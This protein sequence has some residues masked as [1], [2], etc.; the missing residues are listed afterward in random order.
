[1]D[2]SKVELMTL[3]HDW[4]VKIVSVQNAKSGQYLRPGLYLILSLY[5]QIYI[6]MGVE[7]P[8]LTL[9]RLIA[10]CKPL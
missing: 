3:S 7:S 6:V 9:Q 2:D 8:P 1:M 4:R 5:L 10:L